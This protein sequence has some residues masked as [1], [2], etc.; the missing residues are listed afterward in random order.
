MSGLLSAPRKVLDFVLN[1]SSR[2]RRGIS[3]RSCTQRENE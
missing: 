1:T 3:C 2:L